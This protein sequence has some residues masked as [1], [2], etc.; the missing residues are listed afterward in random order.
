MNNQINNNQM[1]MMGRL[2]KDSL[3][4]MRAFSSK[5]DFADFHIV[6]NNQ[7]QPNPSVGSM[8]QLSLQTPQTPNTGGAGGVAP[9]PQ[10]KEFNVLSLCRVGLNNYK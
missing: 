5:S 8:P 9:N 7:Q 6:P 10:Q 2:L 4:N 3:V 1:G